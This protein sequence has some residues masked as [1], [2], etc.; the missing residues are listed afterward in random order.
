VVGFGVAIAVA[1]QV[2]GSRVEPVLQPARPAERRLVIAIRFIVDVIV[3]QRSDCYRSS[4]AL[5]AIRAA[6]TT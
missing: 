3:F 1:F 2:V 4:V 6:V 5:Q